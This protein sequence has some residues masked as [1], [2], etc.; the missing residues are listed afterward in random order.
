MAEYKRALCVVMLQCF[1]ILKA[2]T[3]RTLM[4]DI[5]QNAS[6]SAWLFCCFVSHMA[7]NGSY[8]NDKQATTHYLDQWLTKNMAAYGINMPQFT[9]NYVK[10]N[11]SQLRNLTHCGLVTQYHDKIW[12]NISPGMARCRTAPRHYP[13]QCWFVRPKDHHLSAISQEIHQTSITE[14]SLNISY[15]KFQSNITGA[16]S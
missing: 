1:I 9:S 10:I 3:F 2:T 8:T 16:M 14:I 4:A 6:Q 15:Y 13:N 12:V 7:E 11:H 5:S